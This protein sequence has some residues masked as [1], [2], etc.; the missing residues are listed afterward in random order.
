MNFTIKQL[1]IQGDGIAD[2]PE[3]PVYIPFTLP[4]EVVEGEVSGNRIPKPRIIEPSDNRVK[5]PCPHFKSCGGCSMQHASDSLLADWKTD[6]VR[7][8]LAAHD[9][10]SEFRPIITSPAQSR[11]RATFAAQRTK[12]GVLIGFHGRASDTV[13]AIPSCKLLHPDIMATLPAMEALTKIGAS[14]KAGIS[15]SVTQSASGPDVSVEDAKEADGP[16]M[17]ELGALV[18]QF[19]LARL[20]WN[21]EVVAIRSVPVQT[22]DGVSVSPPVGAFLQATEA[23]QIS[24]TNTVIEAVGNA[25]TIVD[26]FAGCGTFSLPLAK[27]ATV[28]AVEGDAPLLDALDAAWRL[29][30]GLKTI[31]T[32][33]RDLFRNPML[34]EDLK[35]VDAIV[36]DPPRAGAKAQ[37][38]AL[39]EATV[40]RIAFVSCNPVTFARDAKILV[41]A[42]YTIDWVQ[43]VDQFRWSSHVELVALLTK[44]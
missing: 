35:K 24:L 10:E 15:I 27:Q 28:L 20:S 23:G 3:G 42:G 36:I 17:V 33:K 18:E 19:K 40:S 43:V 25:S 37:C 26:L 21:D 9:L 2:G 30:E 4:G 31:T 14:R 34:A 8:A 32:H 16:M 11:R 13:I 12:K 1:S 41:N 22:F 29:G 44:S 38:E 5:A 6:V 39:S 7:N